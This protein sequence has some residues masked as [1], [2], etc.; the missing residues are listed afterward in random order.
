[1]QANQRHPRLKAKQIAGTLTSAEK[2]ELEQPALF[3]EC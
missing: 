2:G 1:V 3:A